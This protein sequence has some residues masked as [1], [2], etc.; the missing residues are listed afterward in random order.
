MF[1]MSIIKIFDSKII[2]DEVEGD[3][4]PFVA[5]YSK[6]CETLLVY[7][8]VALYREQVVGRIT[9]LWQDIYSLVII[10]VD[11]SVTCKFVEVVLVYR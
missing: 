8:G 3:G 4:T 11:P 7:G 9:V 10:K 6:C 2:D 1:G 5:T